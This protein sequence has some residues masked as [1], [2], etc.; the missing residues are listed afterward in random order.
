MTGRSELHLTGGGDPFPGC[1]IHLN[2]PDAWLFLREIRPFTL[3]GSFL[4]RIRV[5]GANASTSTNVRVVQHGVGTVVIP[6]GPA[7]TPLTIHQRAPHR[8]NR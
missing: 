3:N 8:R 5:N 1:V 4:G 6:H 2:S 7:F